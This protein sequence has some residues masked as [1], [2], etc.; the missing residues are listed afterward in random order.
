MGK[1][2]KKKIIITSCGIHFYGVITRCCPVYTIIRDLKIP[3]RP[4]YINDTY[5]RVYP[6]CF[7]RRGRGE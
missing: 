7:T 6:A 3:S 5:I 4:V 1:M 2:Q